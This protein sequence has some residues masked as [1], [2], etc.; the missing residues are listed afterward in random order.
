MNQKIE[1]MIKTITLRNQ[2]VLQ[3]IKQSQNTKKMSPK[4]QKMTPLIK[5]TQRIRRTIKPLTT[6]QSTSLS[7]KMMMSLNISPKQTMRTK[8]KISPKLQNRESQ[9]NLRTN[10]SILQ[11]LIKTPLKLSTISLT[12][13]LTDLKGIDLLSIT[14][15]L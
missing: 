15:I 7:L 12:Q 5:T 2:K 9:S 8:M 10:L 1:M 6:N 3:R 13:S 14:S 4:P 11:T